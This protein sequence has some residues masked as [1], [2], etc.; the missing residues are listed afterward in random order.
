MSAQ[1]GQA[2]L[3]S[4]EYIQHHLT[5]WQ[6][7]DGFWSLNVDTLLFG[8]LLAGLIIAVSWRVSRRLSVDRPS[9]LQNVLEAL[10]E[11]VDAQ[12]KEIFPGRNPLIAPLAITI[13]LWVF[14]MNTMDLLPVDL[15]PQLAQVVAVNLFGADPHHVYLKV[16]PTADLGTTFGLSLS[17]FVLVVYYNIKI[18]G[19]VGYAKTFLFHPFGKWAVPLNFLMTAVEEIAKPVSL[20]LRL[21]GNMFAGELIFVLIALLPWWLQWVPGGVWA[22]FHILVVTLQA[23]I[24]M[25]LTVVYLGMAH[26]EEH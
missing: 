20:G 10:V 7:G 16:V 15:L 3:S 4:A 2:P 8:W 12:V 24:F 5:N 14:L 19:P 22:I 1:T 17:V 9:G 6:I 26:Q 21:F 18:R 11:F 23:F 13:F 25:V